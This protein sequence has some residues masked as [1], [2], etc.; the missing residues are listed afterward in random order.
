[1]EQECKLIRE[2]ECDGEVLKR[3]A[4]ACRETALVRATNFLTLIL[5]LLRPD[6]FLIMANSP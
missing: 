6:W 5:K 4:F 1:M 2:K 3:P